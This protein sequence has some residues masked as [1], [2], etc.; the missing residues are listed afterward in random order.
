MKSPGGFRPWRIADWSG[1]IRVR[2]PTV[3]QMTAI[4]C[5]AACLSMVLG[6]HGRFVPLEAL[7]Y[8]CGVSRDGTKAGNIVRAARRF[9]LIAEG[10]SAEPEALRTLPLPQIIFWNFN[11]FVVVDGFGPGVVF[12]N[13]PAV[14]PRSVSDAEFDVSFTGVVLTFI[15]GPDFVRGGRRQRV[16]QGV[17][18]RLRSSQ[19]AVLFIFL[20]G[21][22]LVVPGLLVPAFVRI[23]VDYYLIQ[24]FA[25]WLGPL[26]AAMV[27]IA[28]LRVGLTSLQQHYL[29][30]LQ[31]KLAL[32]GAGAFFWR[33]LR[34]PIGFFAQRHGGEI[35]SR[36]GL[37]D[38]VAELI[39]GDMAVTLIDLTAMGFY[40]VIMALYD[41][42]LTIVAVVFAA[43][44][45]AAFALVSRR[46]TDASHKLLLDQSKLTGVTMSGLQMIESF[47]SSGTEDLFFT[48]WAGYHARVVNAEQTLDRHRAILS[49]SP[50]LLSLLGS[51]VVLVIGGAQAM[52]GDISIG[53]LAAF[54]TLMIGFNAPLIRLVH[55]GGQIQEVAA[56]IWRLDDI[57]AH[58][59]DRE[60]RPPAQPIQPDD[61]H[62]D[63]HDDQPDEA[64]ANA[65]LVGGVQLQNVS[66]GFIPTDPPLI[67][68][69]SFDL[70]P[71]TRVALVGG[72][73]SGKSTI[74]KL[75]A[76]LYQPWSGEILFD[77]APRNWINPKLFRNSIAMVDQDIVLFEGTVSDNISLWDGTMPEA[78]IVRA[79]RDAMVHDDIAAL[80]ET[81][82]FRMQEAGRNFS[83]GQRQRI[84]I[85]RALAGNPTLLILDEATSALDSMTEKAVVDNIRKR[86]CTAIIIA[87]RLSTIRDCDEI[88][89]LDHGRIVE[90][91]AH[92]AL[93]AAGAG[94]SRLIKS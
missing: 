69:L 29:L 10:F 19:I 63:Q 86:G 94:Y 55:L 75:I 64:A 83:G 23:F 36:L 89:V 3:L 53:A 61:Q 28:A 9:G 22:G 68:G 47:K 70:A 26:L 92:Q 56:S 78:Q 13:D 50:V 15:T 62:D 31:T 33:V 30:R 51:A 24:G 76:G 59:L 57:L 25:D 4:E 91:G 79:A 48:R 58:D 14:G 82:D 12:L 46:L 54:Q 17:A 41:G 34:L 72:S 65:K 38:R 52:A 73:G 93:L 7:R 18:R 49:S 66:F 11:H 8:E 43:F 42:P 71:G 21:I 39:A 81:Y 6:H 37:S 16:I 44:N 88:I 84:E 60:F 40:I 45:L 90:R 74:G 77:G 67:E 27:A 20:A 35:G 85:A 1:T 2:T 5:G 87:H 80:P 32:R